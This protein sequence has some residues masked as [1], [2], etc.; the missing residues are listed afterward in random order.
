ME[1]RPCRSCQSEAL[2]RVRRTL[3][4]RCISRKVYKCHV[5]GQREYALRSLPL[6]LRDRPQ[7]L[8]HQPRKSPSL[9]P[10]ASLILWVHQRHYLTSRQLGH[11]LENSSEHKLQLWNEESRV[12]QMQMTVDG[13]QWRISVFL[14]LGAIVATVSIATWLAHLA[15]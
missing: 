10:A 8:W 12:K 6:W 1:V 2:N 3:W 4:Q 5:C 11:N 13:R 14:Y 15:G 9:R 7:R